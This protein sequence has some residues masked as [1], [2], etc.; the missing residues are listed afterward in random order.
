MQQQD[1]PAIGARIKEIRT[2]KDWK[3]TD[4]SEKSGVHVNTISNIERG[5]RPPTQILLDFLANKEGYNIDWILTGRGKKTGKVTMA[6]EKANLHAKVYQMERELKEVKDMLK[7]I[8]EK[9]NE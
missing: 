2:A 5:L 4:L 1:L 6:E 8:L 7:M 3:Q 9:L